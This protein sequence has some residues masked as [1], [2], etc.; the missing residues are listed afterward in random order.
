VHQ[1]V[2]LALT[3]DHERADLVGISNCGGFFKA[4]P[5]V[6]FS[7]MMVV[8]LLVVR[9]IYPETKCVSLEDVEKKLVAGSL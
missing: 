2:T 9:T 6:F 7:A 3:L 1:H 4:A 5:F 8:Q